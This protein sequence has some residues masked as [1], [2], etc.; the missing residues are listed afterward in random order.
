VSF[1]RPDGTRRDF[2][3]VEDEV[4]GAAGGPVCPSGGF[5]IYDISG[6]LERDPVKV[7]YWNIDDVRVT[8]DPTN[9]CTAHVFRI[10]PKEKLMTAAFYNGGVRV[11]DISG[12]EGISLG[13]TSFAGEGMRQIGYYRIKGA[14]TWSAKTPSIDPRTGDFHLYGN[15][16]ARGLDVYRFEGGAPRPSGGGRWL[17]G[18]EARAQL[19]GLP[20]GELEAGRD[21]L[22]CLLPE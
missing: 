19:R 21:A 7:G 11:V 8:D 16:I 13:E 1:T 22:F 14:D 15:D 20:D 5:H 6:E 9:T 17:N 12:L 2:L 4:A 10:H 3:I 18:Q